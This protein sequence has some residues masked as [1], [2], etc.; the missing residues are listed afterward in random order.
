[1]GPL[2]AP[3]YLSYGLEK[4]ELL[5]TQAV[6]RMVVHIFKVITYAVFG[7]LTLPYGIWD[8]HRNSCLSG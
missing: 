6:N 5:G 4:E 8:P 3:F 7:N 2:L 1:M